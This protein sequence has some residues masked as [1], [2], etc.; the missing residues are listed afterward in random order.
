MHLL[1]ELGTK[2]LLLT[3]GAS[4]AMFRVLECIRVLPQGVAL[5]LVNTLLFEQA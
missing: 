5:V 4:G 1:L 2:A 3:S